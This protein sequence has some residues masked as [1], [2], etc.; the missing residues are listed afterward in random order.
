VEEA[1][2]SV[3]GVSPTHGIR[4]KFLFVPLFCENLRKNAENNFRP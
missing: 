1:V 3:S 4:E 2:N